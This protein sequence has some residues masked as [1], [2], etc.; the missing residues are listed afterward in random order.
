VALKLSDLKTSA[1]NDWCPGC[2]TGDTLVVSNPSVK[3]IQLVKPGDRVLNAS[4]EYNRVAARIRHRYYGPMYHVHAK[5]FGKI[6]AT[7][8]HPF[9]AVRRTRGRHRHNVEFAEEKVEA[10]HLKVGDYLVFPVMREITDSDRFAVE[11]RKKAKDTRSLPLPAYVAMDDDWLRLSGY[12]ISEGSSHKRSV[13]FSFNRDEKEYIDD[14]IS[15]MYKRFAL[16]GKIEY[17]EGQ[18]VDVIFNSSYLA[19]FFES[20]FGSDAEEKRI[21]HEFMFLPPSKQ[22]ALIRGLWRGDGDF[23][24]SKA[25]Y[26]TTS[27]VLAEQLKM[28]LLRQGIVPITQTESA[29]GIH[30]T[31]YRL[32]V[33]YWRDYNA[34]AEMVG[35]PYHR[36]NKRDKRSSVLKNG[37]V[38][39]PVSK[40]ETSQFDGYVYDLTM[41]DPS[42]TFVTSVT[43]SGNCGD[44]GILNAVQ[45][46]LAEMNVDPSNTVVV[47]GIGCS[48]KVSHF[49]KTYGVHTLHGRAVPFATGIKL[50]NPNLEVIVEGG[51]GDGLGIGVGHFVSSGRRNIDMLYIIHDN[52]VYGLTK[53]QASPTLGLGKKTKSLPSPNINGGINPIM[54]AIAAGYTWVARGYSY[55]VRHL[56][57]LIMKGIRHKGYAFLDVLQPCPTYNDVLTKEYW[58]GEGNLDSAGKMQ[59][60]TYKLEDTGY[61]GIVHSN[62]EPEMEKKVQQAVL[63]SFEFGDHTPIGVFYQNEFVPT[64]EERLTGRSPSYM[65]NPPAAQEIAR[66]DGTPL[67]NI[68]RLLDELRVA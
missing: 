11:Y 20:I 9:V 5:S 16:R 54:L 63:K 64:Y 25:R 38:Y 18:G 51:D 61:D 58:A 6:V 1:H 8:E 48:G 31:A 66:P 47:S 15:L 23:K 21:P 50:A 55:D 36:E 14:T 52:E 43:A 7:P 60:R 45:M 3:Q 49:I 17:D 26:T 28:L 62:D 42:H 24:P 68:S 4:G 53:G 12:Y 22:A 29:H 10:S 44:F 39:L 30:R 13:I 37:R 40:I 32:Y 57:D 2:V 34:L 33:S 65:T 59:P 27:V 67:T 19:E 35:V 56:K 46:A 41:D